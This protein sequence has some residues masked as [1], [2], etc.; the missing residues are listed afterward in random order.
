MICADVCPTC[1]CYGVK[2]TVN[3]DP[4]SAERTITLYSC[5]TNDFAGVAEGHN[6]QT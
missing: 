2:E 6:V 5:K 1:Y 4:G 3:V